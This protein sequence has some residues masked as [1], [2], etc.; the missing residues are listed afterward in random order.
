[1]RVLGICIVQKM[2]R[3]AAGTVIYQNMEEE[4]CG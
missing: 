1:M 3:I 2:V 4:A